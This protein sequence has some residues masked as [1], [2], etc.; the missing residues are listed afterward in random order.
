MPPRDEGRRRSLESQPSCH[1]LDWF[2]KGTTTYL[3][4]AEAWPV[5][6]RCRRTSFSALGKARVNALAD[7]MCM[8][9]IDG[10]E[11]RGNGET[12]KCSSTLQIEHSGRWLNHGRPSDA[13]TQLF[14]I[15]SNQSWFGLTNS[16]SLKSGDQHLARAPPRRLLSAPCPPAFRQYHPWRSSH[17][18]L[19][20]K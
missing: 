14:V 1:D 7:M 16:A 15:I 13:A 8:R 3:A 17:V 5:W 18:T 19:A 9:W 12:S 6:Q 10:C 2:R 20:D 11:I 4:P